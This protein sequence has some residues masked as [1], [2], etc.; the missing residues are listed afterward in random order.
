MCWFWDSI[1]FEC[2]H[3]LHVP[4]N[5]LKSCWSKNGTAVSNLMTFSILYRGTKFIGRHIS[6]ITKNIHYFKRRVFSKSVYIFCKMII[7]FDASKMEV[8][9]KPYKNIAM[10]LRK[11]TMDAVWKEFKLA[12]ECILL[13][14]RLRL[15]S[16]YFKLCLN[17]N[18]LHPV[19][20]CLFLYVTKIG[21]TNFEKLRLFNSCL[22]Y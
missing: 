6:Q 3:I 15:I 11:W 19:L 8:K 1:K 20:N 2:G 18:I 12:I 5:D 14:S 9:N 7:K 16:V 22:L 13:L 10:K 17:R 21:R 4:G